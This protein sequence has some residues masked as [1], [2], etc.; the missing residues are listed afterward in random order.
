VSID[1]IGMKGIGSNLRGWEGPSARRVCE[2]SAM[3]LLNKKR[4]GGGKEIKRIS[5]QWRRS[6]KIDFNAYYSSIEHCGRSF[7][8]PVPGELPFR[9]QLA[10]QT[11]RGNGSAN[12]NSQ[13]R[14]PVVLGRR[15]SHQACRPIG[16]DAR[17]PCCSSF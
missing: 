12:G 8:S 4:R 13:G 7:L 15:L 17:E 9:L 1:T 11:I 5:L 14:L 16:L 10:V 3:V 2:G 6:P